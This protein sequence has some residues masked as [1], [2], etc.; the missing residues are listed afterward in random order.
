MN[1][2]RDCEHGRQVGKCDSCDLIEAENDIER[3]KESIRRLSAS[4]A[5]LQNKLYAIEIDFD[6]CLC[7]IPKT[8]KLDKFVGTLI[9]CLKDLT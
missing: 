4:N 5:M 1:N 8:Q 7:E 9:V 3:L 6:E 2:G